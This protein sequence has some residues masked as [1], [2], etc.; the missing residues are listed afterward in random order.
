MGNAL[1]LGIVGNGFVGNATSGLSCKKNSVFIYDRV[2]YKS[3][4]H[5]C[6][7]D[8]IRSCDLIFICLPTPMNKE[9]DCHTDFISQ[10]IADFSTEEKAKT[11]IRSTTPVGFCKELGVNHFPEFLTEANA[12]VD[13]IET[14]TWVLGIDNTNL[15][16]YSSIKAALTNAK[17]AN[18]IKSDNVF[19]T[20]SNTSEFIKLARNSV[21]ATKVSL[22]NELYKIAEGK[23]IGWNEALNGILIDDRITSSHTKVPCNGN[24]GFGGTCFPK[25]ISNLINCAKKSD[26]ETFIL[27]AA[28]ERNNKLDRPLKDWAFDINRSVI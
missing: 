4:P 8:D 6:T 25:D 21:L 3:H 24:F 27:D 19:L 10:A 5:N 23:H 13:F 2:D 7:M 26:V 1:K 28:Q 14:D 22:F 18:A 12:S 20:Q 9:G 15:E 16:I 17:E 11:F